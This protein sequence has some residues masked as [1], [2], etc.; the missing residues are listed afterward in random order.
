MGHADGLVFRIR[1]PML[2]DF[3]IDLAIYHWNE[4][5]EFS[6]TRKKPALDVIRAA[7]SYQFF[8]G[9]LNWSPDAV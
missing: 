3:S 1:A 2:W 9:A 6:Q 5:L 4:I 8:C 7:K